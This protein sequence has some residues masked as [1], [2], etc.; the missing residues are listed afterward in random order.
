MIIINI[1]YINCFEILNVKLAFLLL[2]LLLL[3]LLI[4]IIIIVNIKICFY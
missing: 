3:Q 1:K 4:L 2:V